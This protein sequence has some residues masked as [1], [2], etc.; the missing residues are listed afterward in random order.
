MRRAGLAFGPSSRT[1][2]APGPAVK[3]FGRG[4]RRRSRRRSGSN[5]VVIRV[6][7]RAELA[8][9]QPAAGI[10][11]RTRNGP[12][13]WSATRSRCGCRRRRSCAPTIRSARRSPRPTKQASEQQQANHDR[14]LPPVTVH[15]ASLHVHPQPQPHS[16]AQMH[17]SLASRAAASCTEAC[18]SAI[19]A[20]IASSMLWGAARCSGAVPQTTRAGIVRLT[21]L[22]DD[23]AV[24]AQDV[25]TWWPG[26]GGGGQ[27]DD[28]VRP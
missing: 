18:C 1:R 25:A 6:A 16:Q 21:G 4:C 20:L 28:L 17:S 8:S 26:A 27:D 15:G 10:P 24:L 22:G 19:W 12:I 13:G 5:R 7:G 11:G 23:R 3:A 9:R 2:Q 14:H